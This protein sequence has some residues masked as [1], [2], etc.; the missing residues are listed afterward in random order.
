MYAP[1]P[2]PHLDVKWLTHY[3]A[4]VGPDGLLIPKYNDAMVVDYR[5]R[6]RKLMS[7][8]SKAAKGKK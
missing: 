8:K 4:W 6:L 5:E 2:P 1:F 3:F 7:L